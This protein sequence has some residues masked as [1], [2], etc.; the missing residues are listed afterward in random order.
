MGLD[1]TW[2]HVQSGDFCRE[3]GGRD[4]DMG[5]DTTQKR[6]LHFEVVVAAS[7]GMHVLR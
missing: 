5:M 2:H 1:L 3:I 4:A 6:G 7:D